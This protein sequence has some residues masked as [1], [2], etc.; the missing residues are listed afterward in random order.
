M[1]DRTEKTDAT[2]LAMARGGDGQAFQALFDRYARRVRA[3]IARRLPAAVRRKIS[4]SD[5]VQEARIVAMRQL[6]DFE[7]R[8]AGS[9]G[10][11]LRKI[12][13]VKTHEAIRR[14]RGPAKRDVAREVDDGST[15]RARNLP[16]RG[17]SPSEALMSREEQ[18]AARRA[19]AALPEDYR[20]IL[21]LTRDQGL[22]IREAAERM[23]RSL[24]AAKKLSARALARFGE[25]LNGGG[26]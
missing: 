20:E 9:F 25:L 1:G 22:T 23:G 4:I 13:E 17:P 19:L 21:Y 26:R 14:Y 8:G 3:A 7:D 15:S 10:A 6:R 12:V 18:A 11:W 2:L 24:E 5:V 16:A